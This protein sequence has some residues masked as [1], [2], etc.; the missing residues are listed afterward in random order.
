MNR[1]A[2]ALI[3]ILFVA[4]CGGTFGNVKTEIIS[5]TGD[6]LYTVNSKSDALVSYDDQEKKIKFTVDNKGRASVWETILGIMVAKPN[7]T[8]GD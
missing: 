4:G 1:I 5:G 2:I 6:V 7:I 8:I 3:L